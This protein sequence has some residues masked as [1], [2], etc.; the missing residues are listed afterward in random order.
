[1]LMYSLNA[2]MNMTLNFTKKIRDF[3]GG[4]VVKNLP[5]NTRNPGSF[6]VGELKSHMPWMEQLG[7]GATATKAR[8]SQLE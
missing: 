7:P 1:M 4:P 5:C 3:P 6:L 8:T 2:Q